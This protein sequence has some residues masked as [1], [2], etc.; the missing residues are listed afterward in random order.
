M[1]RLL[2]ISVTH[3]GDTDI[4]ATIRLTDQPIDNV[5][6][7]GAAATFTI[8]HTTILAY[9]PSIVNPQKIVQNQWVSPNP[10]KSLNIYF[11]KYCFKDELILGIL[12][13]TPFSGSI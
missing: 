1:N 9:F 10:L 7:I 11:L 3:I 6:S 8:L 12:F 13:Q 5:I 4:A 2:G